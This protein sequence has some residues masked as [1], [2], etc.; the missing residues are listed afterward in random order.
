MRSILH[1]AR[2]PANANQMVPY[3]LKLGD[4]RTMFVEL[5]SSLIR[6]DRDGSLG[7]TIEG[8]RFLDRLRA[9]AGQI[10]DRPSAGQIIALREALGFTQRE[11]GA[12]TGVNK[13]TVSRW[14]RGEISPSPASVARLRKLRALAAAKGVVVPQRARQHHSRAHS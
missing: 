10:G 11:L 9:L 5:P 4:G 14:E 3:T 6:Y 12:K 1:T 13:L 7:F 2:K 8:V